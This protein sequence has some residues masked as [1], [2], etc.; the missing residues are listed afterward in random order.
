MGI[1]ESRSV[2]FFYGK[3][4]RAHALL[5]RMEKWSYWRELN[6]RPAPYQGAAIPLSHS[7]NKPLHVG[8]IDKPF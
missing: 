4:Y 7:S 3:I 6:P 5:I 1:S 2:L 8:S